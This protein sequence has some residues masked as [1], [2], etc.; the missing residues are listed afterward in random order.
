MDTAILLA[1]GESP[2]DQ[3]NRSHSVFSGELGVLLM[4][5]LSLFATLFVGVKVWHML[6]QGKRR[7][8]GR[9]RARRKTPSPN[10][11]PR[12]VGRRKRRHA[13]VRNPTL[14]ET[15]GLPPPRPEGHAPRHLEP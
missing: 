5:F 7:R 9:S 11:Q 10:S 1:Q 14:A 4:I 2:A 13:E 12:G 8:S 15:E 6:R 3:F